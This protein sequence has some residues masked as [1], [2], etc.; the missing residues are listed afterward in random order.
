MNNLDLKGLIMLNG[1]K[2]NLKRGA[3]KFKIFYI[4]YQY[5]QIQK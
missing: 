4:L 5:G 2:T 1:V 3:Q